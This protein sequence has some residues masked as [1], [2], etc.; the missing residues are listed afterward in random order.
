V[1]EVDLVQYPF[2]AFFEGNFNQGVPVVIGYT[3]EEGN[4]FAFL[5]SV[6]YGL[7]PYYSMNATQYSTAITFLLANN[8]FPSLSAT[9]MEWYVIAAPARRQ[10]I[11]FWL[12]GTQATPAS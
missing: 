2:D 7:D 1:D 5:D 9:V 4:L 8:N 3:A 12:V 11:N 10:F 6:Q